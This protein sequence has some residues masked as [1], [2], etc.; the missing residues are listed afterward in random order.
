VIELREGRG[1]VIDRVAGLSMQ[2]L[3]AVTAI[4]LVQA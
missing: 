1:H 2:Q 4:E 3:Q